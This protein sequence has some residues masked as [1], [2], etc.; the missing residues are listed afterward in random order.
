METKFGFLK[1]D[2]K[3]E[4]V[5]EIARI[6]LLY[7]ID[8]DAMSDYASQSFDNK[9]KTFNYE[10]IKKL[11]KNDMLFMPI[12]TYKNGGEYYD[13]TSE[14]AQKLEKLRT[15]SAFDYLTLKTNNAVPPASDIAIINTLSKDYNLPSS[16][17]NVI[18]DYT[19]ERCGNILNRNFATKIAGSMVR[20]KI[21]NASD[22]MNFVNKL[23]KSTSY[24][25][26]TSSYTPV[27]KNNSSLPDLSD[28]EL[29]DL[30]D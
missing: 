22:A 13:G 27:K 30:L 19:L 14:Y 3:K 23:K 1:S 16:V 18:V 2:F 17:I 10:N 26:E 6:A 8:E 12:G 28:E 5:D 24:V 21:D 29:D 11:A 9:T 15:T 20:E 25:S 4:I 7:G